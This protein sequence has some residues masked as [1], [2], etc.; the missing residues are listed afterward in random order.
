MSSGTFS[1][2]RYVSRATTGAGPGPLISW[3]CMGC[4]QVRLMAGSKGKGIAKR[5]AGCV[6]KRLAA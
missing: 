4:Q 5:C 3:R 6:A 1:A 2:H